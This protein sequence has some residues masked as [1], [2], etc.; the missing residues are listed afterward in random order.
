ML[1]MADERRR[2]HREVVSFVRRGVRM[3][4]SQKLAWDALAERWVVPF[5]EGETEVS[6][7]PSATPLDLPTIF[8]R[9]GPLYVEIGSGA[10]DSP[11][12]FAASH[13]DAN[14]L[15]LEVFPGG[16]AATLI[17]MRDQGVDNV[18]LLMADAAQA[19]PRLLAPHSVTELRMFFPDPWHKARH[20]KRRLASAEFGNLVADALVPG[21]RWLI[22]TDWE[23][24]ATWCREQLDGHPRLRNA[25]DGW[26]PR[27]PERPLTKYES[28]GIS[29]G[30]R[31][32]DLVYEARA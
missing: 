6:V 18:R 2:V 31:I 23:D 14:V 5:D 7:A 10:G 20:H 11:V 22:A 4:P 12:A 32:Y 3:T 30:R 24:Y 16:V 19:L 27:D 13:P 26:A 9:E 29:E 25:Y 15:A 28:R 17:K 8:G 21:G 1:G